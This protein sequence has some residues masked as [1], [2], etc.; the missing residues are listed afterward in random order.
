MTPADLRAE[1]ARRRI[2]LYLLAPRVGL[3]PTRLGRMLNEVIPMPPEVAQGVQQ[4]L[5][6]LAGRSPRGGGEAA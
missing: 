4:A 5:D 3:H 1:V 6:R 2:K